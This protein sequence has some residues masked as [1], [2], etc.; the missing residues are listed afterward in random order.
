ELKALRDEGKIV[1]IGLSEVDVDTLEKARRITEIA[2]VQNLY[3]LINRQS[4]AVVDYAGR[5]GITFIP[6]F[7]VATGQLAR[8]GGVLDTVAHE[9]RAT[10]AQLALAWL[11]RRSPVML[12]IPGTASVAHLEENVA[13]AGIE[14]SDDGFQALSALA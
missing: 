3:N 10:P 13:A 8:P 11:L 12:P 9:Y 2:S 4:E 5:E 7:P 14:L 1:N 6:W